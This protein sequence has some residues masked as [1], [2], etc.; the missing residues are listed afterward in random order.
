MEKILR[1]ITVEQARTHYVTSLACIS[2][3]FAATQQPCNTANFVNKYPRFS[4]YAGEALAV[5]VNIGGIFLAH[6]MWSTQSFHQPTGVMDGGKQAALLAGLMCGSKLINIVCIYINLRLYSK[7]DP[8]LGATRNKLTKAQFEVLDKQWDLA[9]A[10]IDRET[11]VS[12][13]ELLKSQL[14]TA[15]KERD[16]Q[17]L[18]I[19]KITLRQD[20]AACLLSAPYLLVAYGILTPFTWYNTLSTLAHGYW[21][22]RAHKPPATT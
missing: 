6:K 17:L 7:A 9:T 12:K 15:T 11:P 20:L 16:Q 10:Q 8:E 2:L 14:A 4:K 22:F 3:L 21:L 19:T 13:I 18:P 1:I 5:A